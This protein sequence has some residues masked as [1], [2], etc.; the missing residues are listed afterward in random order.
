MMTSQQQAPR[1][2]RQQNVAISP[3]GLITKDNSADIGQ[4]SVY[5]SVSESFSHSASQT[6]ELHC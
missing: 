5:Q 6:C 2:M 3:M 1:V 4:Q